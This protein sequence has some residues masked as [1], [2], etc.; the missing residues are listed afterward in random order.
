M[1]N[2]FRVVLN[3]NDA[4]PSYANP[5]RDIPNTSSSNPIKPELKA[6]KHIQL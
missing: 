5:T 3:A 1:Q 6:D 4:V 2:I